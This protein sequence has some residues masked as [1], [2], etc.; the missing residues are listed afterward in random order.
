MVRDHWKR[1]RISG[2]MGQLGDEEIGSE[3]DKKG[4]YIQW[5]V[6]SS[7]GEFI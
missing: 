5:P 6:V 7:D 2:F 1:A 3:G 4:N